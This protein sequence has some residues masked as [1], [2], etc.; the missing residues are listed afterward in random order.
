MLEH[1]ASASSEPYADTAD[2]NDVISEEEVAAAA[3]SSAVRVDIAEDSC[4]LRSPKVRRTTPSL[5]LTVVVTIAVCVAYSV[6]SDALPASCRR[7]TSAALALCLVFDVIFLIPLCKTSSMS[8][9][10][11]RKAQKI[12][13]RN[14]GLVGKG[15]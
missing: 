9:I 3:E 6:Q 13:I 14:G 10:Q 7:R 1:V 12:E 15:L 4:L 2:V 5:V 8:A 11:A